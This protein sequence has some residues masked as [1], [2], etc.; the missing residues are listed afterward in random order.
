MT[1]SETQYLAEPPGFKHI[2]LLLFNIF[3]S[4]GLIIV[5][6]WGIGGH[7]ID[8]YNKVLN[9]GSYLSVS[10]W[11]VPSLI[12]I[13]MFP[14]LLYIML[15]RLCKRLTQR[16]LDNA[17]KYIIIVS[18]VFI[19]SRLVYGFVLTSY[20]ENNGYSY[21]Y[22]YS[23][24]SMM[25]NNTWLSDPAYCMERIAA[26]RNDIED[27]FDQQDAVGKGLTVEYVQQE[28]LK[29]DQAE[30]ALHPGLYN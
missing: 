10:K 6:V 5:I 2:A 26:H 19:A 9:H 21:C 28:I 25:G 8:N 4:S 20:L 27:W 12:G 29:M 24:S 17:M 3:I 15:L 7:F 23:S 13:F 16:K 30:R 18:V 1:D 22:Y 14:A 11:A